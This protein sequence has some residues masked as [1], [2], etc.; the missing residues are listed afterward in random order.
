[1]KKIVVLNSG[2][3]DSAVLMKMATVSPKHELVGVVFFDYGQ[4]NML[5]ERLAARILSVRAG[6]RAESYKGQHKTEQADRLEHPRPHRDGHLLEWWVEL[7]SMGS[8]RD[9]TGN[10]GP[11]VVPW[12]NMVFL[13][14]AANYAESIGATEIWYGACQDDWAEYPDCRPSFVYD[15][16][17]ALNTVMPGSTRDGEPGFAIRAPLLELSKADVVRKGLGLGVDFTATYSCYTPGHMGVPCRTCSSCRS[18]AAA[19]AEVLP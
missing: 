16:T 8:M 15:L 2:G 18:R 17:W 4:P 9:R 7:P 10:A 11:R 3:M 12:R 6:F 19:M 1:M 5:Q 13:S 14:L